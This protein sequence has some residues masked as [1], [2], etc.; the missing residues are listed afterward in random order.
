MISVGTIT[1]A[2][3]LSGLVPGSFQLIGS[4]NEPSDP[5]K[6]DVVITPNGSGGYAVQ[7]R[8]ARLGSGN[9]PGLYPAGGGHGLGGQYRHIHSN[10]YCAPRPQHR[11]APLTQREWHQGPMNETR[12]PLPETKFGD[13]GKVV[14]KFAN[15][16]IHFTIRRAIMFKFMRKLRVLYFAFLAT[17]SF[18]SGIPAKHHHRSRRGTQQCACSLS[19][20]GYF[21]RSLRRC[22]QLLH[23]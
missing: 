6:P 18:G 3:A 22:W 8:A 14:R 20:L 10:L 13:P 4:S 1:A 16:P 7:L 9:W 12:R 23:S 11:R 17:A 15:R 5:S 2:D 19:R 21:C